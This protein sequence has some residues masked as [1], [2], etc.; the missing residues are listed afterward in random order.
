[1]VGRDCTQVVLC[2]PLKRL[3]VLYSI[4]FL[5]EGG[6]AAQVVESGFTHAD[7]PYGIQSDVESKGA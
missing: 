5:E 6:I 1:M 2:V 3:L 4:R 7:R